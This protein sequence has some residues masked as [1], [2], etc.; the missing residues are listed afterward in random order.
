V[1][2]KTESI[3]AESV[4]DQIRRL[5]AEGVK[6]KTIAKRLGIGRTTLWRKLREMEK[7]Q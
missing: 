6:L 3:S 1:Q 2:A 5:L 7:E 4:E